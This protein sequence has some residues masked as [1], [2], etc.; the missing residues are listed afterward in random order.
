MDYSGLFYTNFLQSRHSIIS[1]RV[2]A[3]KGLAHIIHLKQSRN[4]YAICYSPTPSVDKIMMTIRFCIS[5]KVSYFED[6][7]L[8]VETR[9]A[10][11]T[12]SSEPA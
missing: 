4:E 3:G 9:L 11:S 8:R 5:G 7:T 2:Y 12:L 1:V 10:N 6:E